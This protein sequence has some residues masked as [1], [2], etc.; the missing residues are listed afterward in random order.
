MGRALRL[1]RL[2]HLQEGGRWCPLLCVLASCTP[3][4]GNALETGS[5][6]KPLVTID[7]VIS[8]AD[9]PRATNVRWYDSDSLLVSMASRNSPSAVARLLWLDGTPGEVVGNGD[10]VAPSPDGSHVLEHT[11]AGWILKLR[12][13]S[14][15]Q[16]I[17]LPEA[18]SRTFGSHHVPAW[19]DDGEYVAIIEHSRPDPADSYRNV[20]QIDGVPVIEWGENSSAADEWTGRITIVRT[21]DAQPVS[22]VLVEGIVGGVRWAPGHVLYYSRTGFFGRDA[23]TEVFRLEATGDQPQRVYHST[24]RFQTLVPAI[25]PSKSLLALVL[26]ADNRGWSDFQ[27]IVLV[28]AVSGNEVQRLTYGIPALG[29]DY[30]WSRRGDELYARVRSGGYDAIYRFPLHGEPAPLARGPRRHFDMQLSPDGRRLS[31]RTED[32]FGRKDIR[33]L[34]LESGEERVVRILDE[35]AREFRL[36]DWRRIR[37]TSTDGVEPFGFLVLPPGFDPERRYP[38]LVDVH[39]GGAGSR[40]SLDGPLTLGVARGPLE[41]HA[42]AALGY[43]VLVPDYRSSGMYGPKVIATRYAAG[44]V[45]AIKDIDDIVSG[46][47]HV[48]RQGY[49]DPERVA[50]L[51]HSAGGQRAYVLLTRTNL[52]GA[53]ILNEPTPPDPVSNLITLATG[54]FAGSYPEGILRQRYGGTLAEKPERYKANYMFDAVRIESPTLIMV[55]NEELGGVSH[56]PVEVLFSILKQHGIPAKLLQFVQEGHTYTHP[57]AARVA[58]EAARSWLETHVPERKDEGRQGDAGFA[59]RASGCLFPR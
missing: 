33:V 40:L 42:W 35:P 37:W 12:D 50:I 41:R 59:K 20:E 18:G 48:L 1:R 45:A 25:H 46:T 8:R 13:R 30:T 36:G 17:R 43:V 51:G 32:G 2:L 29:G 34:D 24:G 52:Y 14:E 15:Q 21:S 6:D 27:S 5:A 28:D 9:R 3:A 10:T 57:E 55:G 38:L 7:A 22:C 26:D 49:V 47:C 44:E 58:F 11:S 53:A 19:S 39:G 23:R 54:R 56:M 31:Y 4:A 16:V